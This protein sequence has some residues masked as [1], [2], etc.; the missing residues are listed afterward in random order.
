MNKEIYSKKHP[1][2][3]DYWYGELQ[4]LGFEPK[5]ASNLNDN[6]ELY[7]FVNNIKQTMFQDYKTAYSGKPIDKEH[8]L[9]IM[10]EIEPL[11]T[12]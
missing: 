4:S 2:K 1:H 7:G 6:S 5:R 11:E 12:Q 8:F 10:C 3:K 9:Y